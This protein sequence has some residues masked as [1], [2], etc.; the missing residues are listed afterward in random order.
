MSFYYMHIE[1]IDYILVYLAE[2][3]PP[4]LQMLVRV[5]MEQVEYS[6]HIWKISDLEK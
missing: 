3:Y 4:Y 6:D 5:G 1:F 2:R